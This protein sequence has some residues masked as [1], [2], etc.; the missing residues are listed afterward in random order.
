LLAPARRFN[1]YD[2]YMAKTAS[3]STKTPAA[4]DPTASFPPPLCAIFR[5][6]LRKQGLKF[7]VERAVILDAVLSHADH[8]GVPRQTRMQKALYAVYPLHAGKAGSD[9]YRFLVFLGGAALTWI[10]ATGAASYLAQLLTL[11]RRARAEE[12]GGR[13][14][15]RP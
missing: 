5:R 4:A 3:T 12:E 9:I 2:L 11:R 10:S 8:T 13:V 15:A 1:A 6:F 14:A 7:T